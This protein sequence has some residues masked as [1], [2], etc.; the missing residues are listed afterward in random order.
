MDLVILVEYQLKKKNEKCP[1]CNSENTANLFPGI[2]FDYECLDCGE[3]FKE[4]D[5]VE[6]TIKRNINGLS[7]WW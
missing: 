5:G 1:K 6:I 2:F 3:V 4:H 7:F